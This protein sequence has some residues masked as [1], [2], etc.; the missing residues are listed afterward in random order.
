M[1]PLMHTIQLCHWSCLMGNYSGKNVEWMAAKGCY[2][3]IWCGM[4]EEV[5]VKEEDRRVIYLIQ[6]RIYTLLPQKEKKP[7]SG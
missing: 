7:Y 5:G 4:C 2:E 6:Y 3:F 1:Y